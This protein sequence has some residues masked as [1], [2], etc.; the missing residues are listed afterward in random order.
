MAGFDP[1]V[2]QKPLEAEDRANTEQS[3]PRVWGSKFET[4]RCKFSNMCGAA[5]DAV[6]CFCGSK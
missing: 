6:R 5:A 4:I 3:K 2:F 1:T